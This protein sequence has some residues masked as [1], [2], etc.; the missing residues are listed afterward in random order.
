VPAAAHRAPS[1]AVAESTA[2]Q[3]YVV[4]RKDVPS[5]SHAARFAAA[6]RGAMEAVAQA[7]AK[8]T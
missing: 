2:F 8:I 5:S 3:T 7:P 4:H 1:A 6:L